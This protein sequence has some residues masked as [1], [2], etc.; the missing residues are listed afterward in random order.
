MATILLLSDLHV[1]SDFAVFPARAWR[2]EHNDRIAVRPNRTQRY[3]LRCWTW[4]LAHL[5]ERLDC[6][7]V[8]GDVI[9]GEN[10]REAGRYLSLH[11]PYDQAEAARTLLAPIRARADRFFLVKGTPYHEGPASDAVLWLAKALDATPHAPGR[12]TGTRLWLRLEA[13]G[14]L[15]I[16]ASHHMTRGFV[17]PAGG[18]DRTA[19]LA[20]VAEASGKLPRADVIVRAHNHVKRVVHAYGKH[21]IFQPAW[22]VLTPY[23]ERAMEE[24][25]AEV[26]ADLGAVL[27]EAHDGTVTRIDDATFAFR[28][29][30][31]T[32]TKA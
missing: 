6:V 17:Y 15:M 2:T 3:L 29:F 10:P 31:P 23:A 7:I 20:S 5:P 25:R 12:L 14:G 16:N 8:N 21:V 32:V 1:G 30:W 28:N 18:A 9:D 11:T 24:I 13:A 22:K 27:V 26:L 19:L 4:M